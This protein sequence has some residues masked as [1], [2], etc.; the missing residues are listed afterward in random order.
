MTGVGIDAE[1]RTVQAT[2]MISAVCHQSLS[3]SVA[4]TG[5]P[6]VDDEP[7]IFSATERWVL[8]PSIKTGALLD[9]G[10]TYTG[11]LLRW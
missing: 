4:E 10:G 7:V 3:V 6:M 1:G 8:S 9:G 5:D 11:E 2:Q